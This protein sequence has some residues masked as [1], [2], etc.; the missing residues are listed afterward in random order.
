MLED[1]F[2]DIEIYHAGDGREAISALEMGEVFD[3][4]LLDWEM[5]VM[6]GEAF[7]KYVNKHKA[8]DAKI[9]MVIPIT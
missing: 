3:L 2:K 9:I 6:D 8:T 1:N 7:L 4:I 5:P